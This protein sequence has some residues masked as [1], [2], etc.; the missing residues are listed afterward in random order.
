[1]A[2]RVPDNTLASE[3]VTLLS[4]LSPVPASSSLLQ[5]AKVIATIEAAKN[6]VRKFHRIEEFSENEMK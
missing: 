6:Q 2:E 5:E 1:M 3:M 4:E